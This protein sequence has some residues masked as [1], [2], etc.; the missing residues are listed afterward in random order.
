MNKHDIRQR[1]RRKRDGIAQEAKVR[2]D[3]RI[4]E[5]L[6]ALPEFVSAHTI[7]SYA[8]FRSEVDTFG[9]MQKAQEMDKRIVVPRVFAA[10]HVLM[11]YEI[12]SADELEPG[13]RGIKE[14]PEKKERE[15]QLRDIHL[16]LIPGIAF[17]PAG[18]RLGYG[19]GY[20]DILLAGKPKGMP[21]VALAYEEQVVASLPLEPHDVRVDIVVTPER[22]IRAGTS[23]CPDSGVRGE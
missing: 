11:L 15:L 17:D 2:M 19:G 1:L 3:A 7:L 13:Y 6:C 14:P 23:G 16:V 4:C 22:I 21:V 12:M 18:N 8:S 20:Y 9:I 10:E 5:A